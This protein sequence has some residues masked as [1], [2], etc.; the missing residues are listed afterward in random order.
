MSAICQILGRKDLAQVTDA[1]R[2][3]YRSGDLFVVD[4]ACPRVAAIVAATTWPA[5]TVLRP[6]AL[7]SYRPRSARFT[8]ESRSSSPS[9][10]TPTLVWT[11]TTSL[12]LPIAIGTPATRWQRRSATA[13]PS[14]KL[15]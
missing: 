7:A 15:V 5:R 4:V 1:R 12:A 14:A 8:S 10:A 3:R 6:A 13:R 11:A 9:C 2:E